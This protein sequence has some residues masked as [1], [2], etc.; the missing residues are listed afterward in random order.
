MAFSQLTNVK[1]D[2]GKKHKTGRSERQAA[3]E[4]ARRVVGASLADPEVNKAIGAALV[5]LLDVT[6]QLQLLEVSL[7]PGMALAQ[8]LSEVCASSRSPV[9]ILPRL[10]G[11]GIGS[12][13]LQTLHKPIL[14][15]LS[16]RLSKPSSRS[17]FLLLSHTYLDVILVRGR[18]RGCG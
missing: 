5:H 13:T 16:R 11:G 6:T 4:Q 9:G 8:R 17:R 1:M 14:L 3:E 18:R 2:R 10:H 7:S 12:S 15:P